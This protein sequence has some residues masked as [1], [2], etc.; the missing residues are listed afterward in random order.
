M[1]AY[2]QGPD[3]GFQRRQVV[4]AY[5][6]AVLPDQ[7]SQ[8]VSG[9]SNTPSRELEEDV[10]LS[11]AMDVARMDRFSVSEDVAPVGFSIYTSAV[12]HPARPDLYL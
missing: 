3:G 4:S 5:Q 7:V 9:V 11:L 8:F 6:E 1:G 2:G 12:G 10:F